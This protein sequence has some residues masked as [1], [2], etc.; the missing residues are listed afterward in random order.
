MNDLI[1]KL[2]AFEI[3][4]RRLVHINQQLR[5]E[6]EQLQIEVVRIQ[7]QSNQQEMAI[8]EMKERL[9]EPGNIPLGGRIEGVQDSKA[10]KREIDKY[11][12]KIDKL[13]EVI[14]HS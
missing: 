3:K 6:N 10:I 8:V 13:I 7:T 1:E 12:R 9:A 5:E 4:I 11:V 2:D 14:E